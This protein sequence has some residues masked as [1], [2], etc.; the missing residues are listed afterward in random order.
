M[1]EHDP[2]LVIADVRH[3]SDVHRRRNPS[4]GRA[5]ERCGRLNR[6]VLS[7]YVEERYASELL[8]GNA[9]GLGYLLKERVAD[10]SDFIGAVRRVAEGGTVLDPEVVAQLLA[11]RRDGAARH[12]DRR[13][14]ARCWA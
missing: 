6:P 12:A 5:A 7:Q 2:D 4:R 1:S 13:A 8:G 11:R 10:V 14:S 9:S 3:A